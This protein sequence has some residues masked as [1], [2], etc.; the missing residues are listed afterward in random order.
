MKD[1]YLKFRRLTISD[2]A[3]YIL[4][5]DDVISKEFCQDVISRFEKDERKVIGATIGGIN[6]KIKKSVDL[7]ISMKGLREEWQDIIDKIG[8]HVNQALLQYQEYM[9]SDGLDRQFSI[10]KTINNSTIGLPQ[11]QKT[12][13]GGFYV[14]HHDGDLNRIFTYIF[15]LNDIKEDI[16]GTTEF[17]CG[18]TI[19]PKAGKLVIFPSSLT[20]IHRG[21]EL[22][23]GTKYIM[24]NFIYQ[25]PPIFRHPKDEEVGSENSKITPIE[26]E[27]PE[28]END[29]I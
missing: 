3:D 2:M 24:T 27:I 16:G 25:G 9:A 18:K 10:Y 26:E 8:T 6:E 19:Q 23:E 7:P 13:K 15:Y 21:T 22:K 1:F 28:P 14:W 12:E 17:L 5:I 20:Y 29:D 4:E 11:I